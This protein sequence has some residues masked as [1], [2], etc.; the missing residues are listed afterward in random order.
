MLLMVLG[1]FIAGCGSK[2]DVDKEG[3][4]AT[5]VAKTMAA[6]PS[7]TPLPSPSPASPTET[8]VAVEETEPTPEFSN[9]YRDEDLGFAFDYPGEWAVAY[10][11]EQSRGGFFQ[12]A[13]EGFQPDPDAGGLPE[14]EILMQLTV[15]N[16]DPKGDLEAF[17]EVRRQAWDSSGIEAVSEETWSWG[18]EIPAMTFTLKGID[19]QQSL[20]IFTYVGDRYLV[21][22]TTM[23]F[24]I[25]MDIART[26]C[27]P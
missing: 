5:L 7:Q 16:W 22:S 26:L 8:P 14:Q 21:F 15:L 4:V 12:F 20:V 2:M 10:Q 18:G 24:Q 13:R 1:V 6:I 19:G 11:E 9:T 23:D 3:Q 27:L 25:V 17:L